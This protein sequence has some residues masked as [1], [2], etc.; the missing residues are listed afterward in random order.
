MK[1]IWQIFVAPG[2]EKEPLPISVSP[3]H[4]ERWASLPMEHWNVILDFVGQD[5]PQPAEKLRMLSRSA[6]NNDDDL[7]QASREELSELSDMMEAWIEKIKSAPPLIQAVSEEIPDLYLNEEHARMLEAVAA[8][9]RE[10]L[11]LGKPFRAWVE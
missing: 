3:W 11:R 10:A 2:D 1:R 9:F 6:D 4:D 5:D 8:V 7:V